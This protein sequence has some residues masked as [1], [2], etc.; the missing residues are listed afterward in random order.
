M[1]SFRRNLLTSVVLLS[2]CLLLGASR[3]NTLF[4]ASLATEEGIAR[5]KGPS[6]LPTAAQSKAAPFL[7][8]DRD[9]NGLS[10]ALQALLAKAPPTTPVDVVVTF[11]VPA[12]AASAQRA[13]GPF[14]LKREFRIIHGF[15]ATLTAAQVSALARV[16][17]VFRVEEDFK[18]SAMLNAANA[19]FGT[20]RARTFFA[21][22]GSNIGV[23]VVD[24]G[25]DP[26][27]E[28]LD[29]A[30][31]VVDFYDAVN[32]RTAAYD[33]HGHGTHV[34]AI[35]AGD[36]IGGASAASFRG[37][38]PEASI[39]AA[40]VL[41]AAGSG[42]ESDVIAGV[43]WC[44]DPARSSVGPGVRIISLSLG[45][46]ASSDGN[47]ALSQAVNNAV[48]AGKVTVV[49]AGNSGADPQTIGSPA[50]AAQAITVG[51]AAEWS[52]A[53][54]AA[55]HS[56][57]V[58][59]AWFSSRGPTVDN[60]AKP[61]IVAPGVSVTSAQKGTTSGYVTWSGTSMATPFV[62]GTV[63]LALQSN[64]SLVPS[65]VKTML[66]ST[67]QDRGPAGGDNDWGAG[68][69]D[70]YA[71]VAEA[72]NAVD[73]PTLFPSYQRIAGSVADNG[74]WTWSFEVPEG[75]L[76]VPIGITL[77]IEGKP[78]CSFGFLDLCLAYEWSPDLDA[79]LV[80]PG[81][82]TPLVESTCPADE[83]CGGMGRQE[84]LHVM[85]PI[86]GTYTVRV[87]PFAGDP[88][89]GKGGSFALDVST[90]PLGTSGGGS[91]EPPP[92]IHVGD[93]DGQGTIQKRQW[94][95]VVTVT[96]HDASH[97]P[98]SDATVSGTWTG[99]YTGSGSCTTTDNGECTLKSGLMNKG[100]TFVVFT[101]GNV[102]KSD[103]TYD[104]SSNH[105]PDGGSSG[106]SITVNKP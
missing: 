60:R 30:G 62:S 72:R 65:Q 38:A 52:A 17:G 8:A 11:S 98:I 87:Y 83:E 25:I 59:L 15:A 105:D 44:A 70:G 34:A 54:A 58:F 93:L 88:N 21:V 92:A 47:D 94:R 40:K 45:S 36:G 80:A 86:A 4:A 66:M 63:A 90:G 61:D 33:D 71:L 32:G 10:D 39:Y 67:A 35:A 55:N 43:D 20:A 73:D 85:P 69:L 78:E 13:V 102:A 95:A 75:A 26:G 24:T 18:V 68:L 2:F 91:T 22:S 56:D 82:V 51:A 37:V 89:N 106:T 31:K 1:K 16:P 84:T 57:G 99:G 42:Y 6:A 28:Q 64:L 77:A 76:H 50:A 48:S 5:A 96:I 81:G 23:C 104:A 103:W 14:Q 9:E 79:E 74:V 101:V 12:S 19:D 41:D 100:K 49:A 97:Q 27:H 53:A 29:A 7:L 3:S 46:D